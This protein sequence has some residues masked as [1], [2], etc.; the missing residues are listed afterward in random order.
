ML[1][2]SQ[3]V[4]GG[5]ARELGE[6]LE[7]ARD[8]LVDLVGSA[9]R[10]YRRLSQGYVLF[11]E[12]VSTKVLWQEHVRTGESA[13]E[14][15]GE[16]VGAGRGAP[17]EVKVEEKVVMGTKIREMLADIKCRADISRMEYT[18]IGDAVN[19]SARIQ[20]LNRKLRTDILISHATYKALGPQEWLRATNRGLRQFKGKSVRARL[21]IQQFD[22]QTFWAWKDPRTALTMPFWRQL[23]PGLKVVVCV[24]NPL[25]VA[26]SLSQ[27]GMSSLAFGL[28]LWQTYYERLLAAVPPANIT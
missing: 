6:E 7:K 23:L 21:L 20:T 13:L 19:L 14:Y 10:E 12:G 2:R 9:G 27:R 8:A 4:V 1:F 16:I 15:F 22:T 3:R 25:E 26:H 18:A 24:R 17:E 5:G 28:R 11:A